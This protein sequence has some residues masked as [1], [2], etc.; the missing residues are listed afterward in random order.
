MVDTQCVFYAVVVQ[1]AQ[2]ICDTIV[3]K[4]K[5]FAGIVHFQR[6]LHANMQ[7][8]DAL[9]RVSAPKHHMS[10]RVKCNARAQRTCPGAAYPAVTQ[11][12]RLG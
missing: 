8:D 4:L 11:S 5:R 6:S 7:V 9:H 1:S 10:R 12:I 2:V 3:H